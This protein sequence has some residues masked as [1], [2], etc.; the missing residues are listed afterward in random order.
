[1]QLSLFDDQDL[2]EI[3]SPDFPGERLMA[4]FNPLLAEKRRLKRERLLAATEGQLTKLARGVALRTKAPLSAA[5]IGVKAGRVV[6]RHKM[7]K[8]IQLMINDGIFTWSR[9]ED[10]I[11]QEA[12]LDGIYV[13]RTSEPV[14][15]LSAAAGV[16]AYKR[17]ALVEQ[18]FRCLK[19]V[20][21]LVRPI[22]H[23]LE[24]R[25]RA[26]VLICV[27]AYYVEWHLRRAWRS[28]LFEDEELDRD[29]QERDPVAAA[30]P[31]ASVRRKKSTHQTAT[32]LPVHSFRT[33]LAH[34][35]G[36]KRETYQVAS[37]P[38]GATIDRLSELDPVQ[39]E[40]LRLLEM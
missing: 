11:K 4:C 40:A 33:L 5:E 26:H 21:L 23:R 31:S 28:L 7:A 38:S 8:H 39:A 25:V 35:G 16:R 2:A 20:D 27:L 3:A 18:L 14:E 13:V 30:R 24:P 9:D 15:R 32:G 34:L 22:H 19:G 37:G 1:L 17:L 29:R 6:G 36:R 12:M 10:S